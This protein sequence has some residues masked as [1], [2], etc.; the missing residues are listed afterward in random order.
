MGSIELL[1]GFW[2]T[3]NST[4]NLIRRCHRPEACKGGTNSKSYCEEGYTGNLCAAC[5]AGWA[6]GPGFSCTRCD[7]SF[8]SVV[9]AVAVGVCALVVACIFRRRLRGA[10]MI[11]MGRP[12]SAKTHAAIETSSGDDEPA[13]E[14]AERKRLSARVVHTLRASEFLELTITANVGAMSL[15]PPPKQTQDRPE[16]PGAPAVEGNVPRAS[17]FCGVQCGSHISLCGVGCGSPASV[18]RFS[19]TNW[20]WPAFMVKLRILVITFQI[21]VGFAFT[22]NIRYPSNFLS[23][24]ALFSALNVSIPSLLSLGC[25]VEPNFYS[26]LLFMTLCPIVIALLL[27]L[28]AAVGSF[29]GRFESLAKSLGTSSPAQAA[30]AA[31]VLMM[32]LIFPG[33]SAT[34][35]KTFA[36]DTEWEDEDE[37]WLRVDYS[38]DCSTDTYAL[39]EMYAGLCIVLYPLGIPLLF[40]YLLFSRRAIIGDMGLGRLAPAGAA[41]SDARVAS[42]A[43]IFASM[44]GRDI[45][46]ARRKAD[47]SVK[48]ISFLFSA[49]TPQCWYYEIVECARR[50]LLTG[51]LVFYKD[52]SSTQ[53]VTAL[54]LACGSLMVL[55]ETM[56]FNDPVD[57][58][59]AAMAQWVTIL[60]LL[61]SL[62]LGAGI[63]EEDGYNED[64]LGAAMVV[65]NA[66]LVVAAVALQIY[67]SAPHKA[68]PAMAL[69]HATDAALEPL[70]NAR[71]ETQQPPS[72]AAHDT[73]EG[74][75]AA[76]RIVWDSSDERAA[77]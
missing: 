66:G 67:A 12:L 49:Y 18:C 28:F 63:T 48:F 74:S 61:A 47:E 53:I 25:V 57:N 35:F 7:S 6:S 76:R 69:S 50:L 1:S 20:S 8:Q 65:I 73:A 10:A 33:V 41:E 24:C 62:M 51:M 31:C 26:E 38:I 11:V 68:A 44:L 72:D 64:V 9:V 70:E 58:R 5:E 32:Y 23:F 16:A 13:Q 77:P 43:A 46:L 2:R 21:I 15:P 17:S 75:V 52:G 59:L 34:I 55:T 29:G 27:A 39:F 30:G 42:Q 37:C 14:M 56:P 19:L 4:T 54:V 71:S 36:K 22:F 60:T 3:R 40:A 45:T